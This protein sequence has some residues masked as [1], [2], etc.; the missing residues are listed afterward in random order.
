M[1]FHDLCGLVLIWAFPVCCV[2][3]NDDTSFPFVEPKSCS[4][5]EFFNSASLQ[6]NACGP[7]QSRSPSGLQ[8]V[9]NPGF[10]VRDLG[11]PAVQCSFCVKHQTAVYTSVTLQYIVNLAFILQTGIVSLDRRR[12]LQCIDGSQNC[13]CRAGQTQVDNL[14]NDTVSCVTCPVTTVGSSTGST[15]AFRCTVI[16]FPHI[17]RCVL[18]QETFYAVSQSCT[19]PRGNLAGGLCFNDTQSADVGGIKLPNSFW[20]TTYLDSSFLACTIYNN[21]T[22]CQLLANMVILNPEVLIFKAYILYEKAASLPVPPPY[23]PQLFYSSDPAVSLGQRAPQGLVFQRNT[24]I[25]FKVAQYDASGHFLGWQD[26]TGGTLQLCPDTQK[27]LDAAYQFGTTY[28]QSCSVQVSELLL[29]F[30]EPVFYELFLQYQDSQGAQRVWPVPVRNLN[31]ERNSP[32]GSRDLRRFFLVDGLAGRPQSLTE[33][34]QYVTYLSSLVLRLYHLLGTVTSF[35]WI[36]M[37]VLIN[38]L[39]CILKQLFSSSVFLHIG[40]ECCSVYLPTSNPGQIPPFQLAVEYSRVSD[41]TNSPAQILFAVTYSMN[42]ASM[43]R[44]TTVALGVLGS[45]S[46]F[47]ALLETSSWSRRAGEQYITMVTVVKFIAFLIGNV[48]NTFFLVT[49]GTGIYWLIAFKGQRGTVG[50]ALPSAGG[51]VETD[52][53]IYLS[54]AFAFKALQL[55]HV[56]VVQV[57]V[58]IFFIDWE[59]PAHT[60]QTAGRRQ[61]QAP[62][63]SAWRTFF[64]ANEWNEIQVV[65]KL[66]PLLQLFAVLL[67]LQVIGVENIAARDLNLDLQPGANN[68]QAPWSPILQYG[69]TAAVWL[70]V[71]LVQVLFFVVIYEHFVE[72]KIRQFVDLCAVSNV[73]VFILM[74]RCYGFY[75]HGRSV[76]GRADIGIEAMHANLRREE[77]SSSWCLNENLCALRG[78]EANSDVQT[79]EFLLTEKVRHVTSLFVSSVGLKAAGARLRSAAEGTLV[80]TMKAYHNMNRFLSSFFEHVHKDMDYI[81]KDKLFLE[82]IMNY[83][84][85][86]PVE[87]SIFYNDPDGIVFSKVLYYSSELILLLFETLLFCIISLGSQNAVLAAIL[88]YVIQQVGIIFRFSYT[89]Q[90]VRI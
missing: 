38:N 61:S 15:C 37:V 65:R 31:L 34:P 66:S 21:L 42:E 24:K 13:S 30:P 76:H 88:T 16:I 28:Q 73:S 9:C 54:L 49:F 87:K 69:I 35:Q 3:Q 4:L 29:R 71:G 39:M 5:T 32:G 74:H 90:F 57:T 17:F 47:L 43:K 60:G 7:N 51:M 81:V 8:C 64:V 63:V 19:C 20:Y 83:E 86:Q 89:S 36:A 1:D 50:V 14:V 12:C 2:S 52:F 70:G 75:I 11:S 44:S 56:L 27:R 41:A 25:S 85:Q 6:C 22:A 82:K 80:Q 55:I 67:V 84:F 33:Q 68:Y 53:I 77:A 46:V 45:I 58:S 26:V 18:C 10:T 79:F 48:A 78:L 59:K 72:D 23:L 40:I 62:S